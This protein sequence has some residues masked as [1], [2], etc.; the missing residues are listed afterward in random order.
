MLNRRG[1]KEGKGN[2]N[3][4]TYV[5]PLSFVSQSFVPKASLY[6]TNKAFFVD[7]VNITSMQKAHKI[8]ESRLPRGM[9]GKYRDGRD[10]CNKNY[11]GF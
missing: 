3:G 10:K 7:L 4:I 8:K 11:V 1:I 9:H 6:T 5:I 2:L